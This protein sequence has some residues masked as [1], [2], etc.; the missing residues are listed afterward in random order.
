MH[1]SRMDPMLGVAYGADP[2]P[3]RHTISSSQYYNLSHL[4]EFV[5]WAPRMTKPYPKSRE[6][7]P[8]EAE[9]VKSAA[10]TCYKQLTDA[11]GGCVFAMVMGVQHWRLF[12]FLNRAMGWNR[13][14][15]D[16]MEAGGRMQTVR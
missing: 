15:V 1:D 9:A 5:P 14:P 12:D 13:T 6:Y 7:E 2:T 3:G 16:Y 4:W 11:A 8:S 10:Y